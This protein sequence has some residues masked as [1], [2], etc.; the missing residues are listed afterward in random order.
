M[1][2]LFARPF[3]CECRT[4]PAVPALWTI[5]GLPESLTL[6]PTVSSANTLVRRRGTHVPSPPYC[7]LDHSPPLA[8]RFIARDVLPL[9]TTRWF[10]SSLSDPTSR[11]APC[12][13]ESRRWWLQVSLSVSRLSPSCLSSLSIPSHP[14]WAVRHYE[15]LARSLGRGG[16]D[17]YGRNM[18]GRAERNTKGMKY[19]VTCAK[20]RS[21]S[22]AAC[23][24]KRSFSIL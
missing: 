5:P 1:P 19:L 10:S 16:G 9:I 18:T 20:A 12:P 7:G 21:Y 6:F 4:I 22:A 3:V 11:W 8:D 24:S 14:L 17:I 13:P 23:R 15:A 2:S